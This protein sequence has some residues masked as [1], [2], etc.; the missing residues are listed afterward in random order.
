MLQSAPACHSNERQQQQQQHHQHQQQQ[1][2]SPYCFTPSGRW[3]GLSVFVGNLAAKEN[4][5]SISFD[6]WVSRLIVHSIA[7]VAQWINQWNKG[8]KFRF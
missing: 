7:P 6:L 1:Q 4:D 8:K 5:T 3:R 2:N